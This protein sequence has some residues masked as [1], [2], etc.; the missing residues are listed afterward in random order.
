MIFKKG[1]IYILV[2]IAI[3]SMSSCTVENTDKT[4]ANAV[5]ESKITVAVSIIPQETFVKAVSGDLVDV[6]TMI[7]PGH[8]PANYQPTPKQMAKLSESKV[9]FSIGVPTEEANI[10]S[11]VVDFN[12]EIKVVALADIVEEVYPHRYFGKDE[13]H[14]HDHECSGDEENHDECH[15]HEENHDEDHGHEENHEEE[16]DHEET[17]HQHS[18][19]D[20]HIWLSPN[21]VKVMI[22]AVKDELVELDPK[23]KSTYEK[24]AAEYIAKLDEVDNEIRVELNEFEGQSFIIFHP[25]FGYFADDYGLKMVTIES[26]GKKAT[27]KKVQEVIDFARKENIKFVF[28]QEEFDNQQAETIANEIEGTTVKVAPLA[29]NYI[30]NLRDTKNMLK[31]ILK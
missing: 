15:D 27:P 3:I 14:K 26:D 21:R 23:N 29:Q 12:S 16:H 17:H 7:P 28:Y 20:P 31:E 22:E 1:C 24:N 11:K 25:A 6:V 30:E 2:L 18:K 9:Y 4:E 5:S 13:M 8:S 10:L 19:R